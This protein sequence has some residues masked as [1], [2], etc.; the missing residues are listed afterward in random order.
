MSTEKPNS[1][2]GNVETEDALRPPDQAVV[3]SDTEPAAPAPESR[4]TGEADPNA[5]AA[6][7]QEGGPKTPD[8]ASG[9]DKQ[10]STRNRS[11]ERRIKKLTGKL[12]RA[13]EQTEAQRKEIERLARENAALRESTAAQPEPKLEDFATP[14]EYAKAYNKWT[15]A[16]EASA[17]PSTPESRK[18]AEKPP[19]GDQQPPEDPAIA[20]FHKAGKDML[21][22]E[23]LE[24]LE[25]PDTAVN[26]IMGEFLV[27]SDLGPAI[28]VHLA[29][30]V[31]LSR[32]I[33]AMP[34]RKAIK[35]LEELEAKAGKGEL[36]VEG[37]LKIAQ[38]N[39]GGQGGTGDEKPGG[40]KPS[41]RRK[42][43]EPP[44][45]TQERGSTA[46][47]ADPNNESMEEYAARRRKEDARRRGYN[48]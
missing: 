11:V 26:Q 9:D 12:S 10:T 3:T 42:P 25:E 30:N 20:A 41:G 33:F 18:P 43:P 35:A 34:A 39:E 21:G 23:F 2:S 4:G 38:N 45:S 40:E 17:K 6:T 1:Q 8:Q 31:E 15:R 27:D 44:S 28:Y 46:M 24:A 19:A 32:E 14:A 22:D 13:E 47:P 37:Q 29:N 36:D 7:D 16:K 5:A 48:V